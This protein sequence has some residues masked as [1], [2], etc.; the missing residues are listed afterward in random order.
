MTLSYDEVAEIIK[1]IDASSCDELVLELGDL[2]LVVRRH[3]AGGPAAAAPD[4]RSEPAA[5]A[6]VSVPTAPAVRERPDGMIE[7]R[8]PMIG[9]FYRAPSPEAP[10]FVEPGTV[11]AEGDPLCLIEVM[12]LNTTVTAEA[13]GRVVEICAE[14]AAMVEYGQALFVIEPA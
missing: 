9:T 4:T 1:L 3:G 13:A 8:A 14:N 11:V 12:K 2:K 6:T 10:P 5:D 7:V